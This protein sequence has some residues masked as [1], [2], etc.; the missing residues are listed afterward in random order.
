M[1]EAGVFTAYTKMG[2]ELMSGLYLFGSMTPTPIRIY[3]KV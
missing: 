1:L 3:K 2:L